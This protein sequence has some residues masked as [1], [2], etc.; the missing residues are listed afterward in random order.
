MTTRTHRPDDGLY[1]SREELDGLRAD[2]DDLSRAVDKLDRAIAALKLAN[3][4]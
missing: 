4:N 3:D 2:I 1:V